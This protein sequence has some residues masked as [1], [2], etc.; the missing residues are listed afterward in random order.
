MSKINLMSMMA[1]TG[2]KPPKDPKPPKTNG[3]GNGNGTDN[4]NGNG[5]GTLW[6]VICNEGTVEIVKEGYVGGHEELHTPFDTKKEAENW[7]NSEYPNNKK[8]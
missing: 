2:P 5:N 7:V 4:G 1:K 6:Y 3:A 8:C